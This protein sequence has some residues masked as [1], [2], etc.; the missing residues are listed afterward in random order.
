MRSPE[1]MMALGVFARANGHHEGAWRLPQAPV[2]PE[3]DFHGFWLKLAQL[4]E[5]AVFDL[6]F[7][8]DVDGLRGSEYDLAALSHDPAR[9][10]SQFEPITLLSALAVST[11]RIGLAGTA[12]TTFNDP[13]HIA[14]K[15][16][17]IDHLSGGRAAWN[18]VTS[19]VSATAANFGLDKH[20]EHDQR[21]RQAQEFVRVVRGLWDSY[22][23]DAFLRD[24]VS[25]V[26]VDTQKLHYLNHK[27]DH[28]SVKG[29]L[30]IARPVQGHPVLIQA[31]ASEPGKALAAEV[32]DVIFGSSGSL[33][34]AQAFYADVKARAQKFGRQPGDVR[35]MPGLFTVIGHTREEAQAKNRQLLALVHPEVGFS[36][37]EELL[38]VSLRE[39]DVD[40]PLPEELPPTNQQKALRERL[41]EKA[42]R[43]KL[44]IRQ[45]YTEQ[46]GSH[47]VFTAVGS[48]SDV[49]D[50][51]EE[52]FRKEGAD[53][54]N[55]MASDYPQGFADFCH[56]VVPE[57][58]KR[59][60]VRAEYRGSTLREHMGLPRPAHRAP[61]GSSPAAEMAAKARATRASGAS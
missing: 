10:I 26:F 61:A 40:G 16:A 3:L 46:I 53:G 20:I 14:R 27:G 12:S 59:G 2:G 60:L 1:E 36:L 25:G 38:G 50:V 42:R 34:G 7:L 24:K 51:M 29:P 56:L 9:Y 21:Y 58:R 41:V 48:P 17:S 8:A 45:L 32:A 18:I 28:L 11:R 31:G 23:D 54:F 13:Y 44:T 5:E 39:H 55:I 33:A 37:L 15:Y 57:L 6:F 19:S 30:N 49:A 52:W 43:E 35:V 4:A 47:G 22:A